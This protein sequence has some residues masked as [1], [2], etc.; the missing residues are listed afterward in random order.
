MRSVTCLVLIGGGVLAAVWDS[1]AYS[2]ESGPDARL[3]GSWNCEL[4]S[5]GDGMTMEMEYDV[6]YARNGTANGSGTLWLKTGQF[7]EM[8]YSVA[9]H[10]E[11][12]IT[13]GH[14]VQTASEIDLVNTSHPHFDRLFNPKSLIPDNASE[15][16]EILL[17]DES[18]L[19]MRSESY[20]TI[21]NCAR[22]S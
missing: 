11:W 5:E 21:V 15:S 14:L 8:V 20:G 3:Y 19:R 9:S 1:S 12:E 7:P 22:D 4:S 10:S 18:R 16:S 2:Q 13:A 17:L 6:A